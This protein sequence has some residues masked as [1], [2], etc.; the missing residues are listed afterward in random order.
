MSTKSRIVFA[1]IATILVM[2]AF[3][4]ASPDES[5]EQA[6]EP[7]TPAAESTPAERPTAREPTAT[8]ESAPPPPP[9]EIV[10]RNGEAV[11]G[12]QKIEVG[13]GDRLT[14]VVSSDAA[15]EI[16]LHG[17]D[18][19]KDVAPG[20]PARFSVKADLEGVFEVESHTAEDRG[21]PALVAQVVVQPS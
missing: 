2:T 4:L 1:A 19:T 12:V 18:V 14:F 15:D 10:L 5:S 3:V 17:Y 6:D 13:T 11:D 9:M 20:K 16:H 7:S 21:V 8:A